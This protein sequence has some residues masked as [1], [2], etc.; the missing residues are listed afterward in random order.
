MSISVGLLPSTSDRDR[1]SEFHA[2]AD[3]LRKS[4]VLGEPTID[5]VNRGAAE[6]HGQ[7]GTATHEPSRAACQSDFSKRASQISFSIHQTS[8][9]L[10]NLKKLAKRTS[11]FENPAVEI[12]QLTS[13]IKQDI[14]AL[15]A[16]ISDLQVLGATQNE[17]VKSSKHS[18]EHLTMIMDTL[19]NRLMTMTKDFK[20]IL[21]FHTE[22]LKV[23]ENRRQ[24]FSASSLKD[25]A[26]PFARQQP[27]STPDPGASAN[28]IP[29]SSPAPWAS[30]LM[31]A[32]SQL[33]HSSLTHRRR[34]IPD[35]ASMSG[36][37][38]QQ[39]VQDTFVQNRV[40]T[41][42]NVES[43]ILELS[44]LFV[45]LANMVAQQSDVAIRIDENM[46]DTL[47]NVEGAQGQLHKYLTSISSNRWLII[48]IF[49]VL[50]VLLLI[51]IVFVA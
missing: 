4:Q 30:H 43:T 12:Q 46:D 37:M 38:Q 49:I 44:N 50:L 26:N 40:A 22:N 17:R 20:D 10:A 36:Q 16:A 23:H 25:K 31:P 35:E 48:K 8:Q 3:F 19:K 14:T 29:S 7:T 27:L 13:V 34:S 39:T 11:M 21:T 6:L 42:Q 2:I 18:A 9:L 32:S 51:F 41:L 24:I 15:S 45:Q 28:P 5:S 33:F 47:S 1:T